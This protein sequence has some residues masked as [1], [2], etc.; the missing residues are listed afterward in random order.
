MNRS[1]A[2][3]NSALEPVVI[4]YNRADHLGRTL[5]SFLDAGLQSMR[6]HVLDN[7]SDDRTP[8]VVDEFRAQWPALTYHRNKYNIGGNANILRALEL[9]DSEYS[10]VIGDDDEWHLEHIAEL[11]D[12]VGAR[13]ADVVRLG[14]LASAHSRGTVAAAE[15]LALDEPFFFASIS[16][17]SATVAR[18]SLL[19]P[20]LA[21][22]YQN[23]GD[24]YPQLVPFMRA[25]ADARYTVY[26]VTNDIVVHIPSTAPAYYFGDLEWYAA[27]FRTGRFLPLRY[28]S[29]FNGELHRYMTRTRK[30]RLGA[31]GWY[32]KVALNYKAHGIDQ[33]PYLACS[34]AYGTGLRITIATVM[35]LYALVPGSVARRLRKAYLTLRG[36]PDSPLRYDRT[37][38]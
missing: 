20:H 27:W 9:S 2:W 16:M 31:I 34:L 37:R 17:I 21:H 36:R 28:R 13:R 33:W 5:R 30:E 38:V 4:T 29:K 12:A 35:L 14:W 18:R 23:T 6:L 24:A 22:A 3:D 10:W 8:E 32:A 11:A 7:A 25:L 1:S 15:D 26:T 19:T